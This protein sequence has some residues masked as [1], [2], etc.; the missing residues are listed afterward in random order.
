MKKLVLLALAIAAYAGS[1][2]AQT[3]PSHEKYVE[4]G[5][6][7]SWYTAYQNWQPGTP[8]YNG[9]SKAASKLS[10]ELENIKALIAIQEP[11]E[12]LYKLSKNPFN[13]IIKYFNTFLKLD[14]LL[15]DKHAVFSASVDTES[16]NK[17]AEHKTNIT[18]KIDNMEKTLVEIGG[19]VNGNN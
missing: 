5:S 18:N 1:V 19:A 3:V 15:K 2:F 11:S 6:T 16:K 10:K 14:L 8:L 13:R 17:I 4:M 7:I 9:D 12:M